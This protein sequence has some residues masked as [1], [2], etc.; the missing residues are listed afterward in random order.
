MFDPNRSIRLASG[1]LFNSESTWR[2]Y[3]PGAGDW[4]KTALLL[5]GPLIV[6]SALLAY[7]LGL[8]SEDA[9][10][11]GQFRPTIASTLLGMVSAAI[12][13]AVVAFIFGALAGVF[14][15]KSSFAFG[16]AATTLAFVPAYI[17]Q[18]LTQ[19][20]W[21]G[22]LLGI[23]LFVYALVLLWKIIPIY[24]EVPDGKRTGH[25]VSSLLATIIIMALF[26]MTIGR[27]LYPDVPDSPFAG[28][29][30]SSESVVSNSSN[31]APSGYL[32]DIIRQGELFKEAS[33]D[34]Y[35]PPADGRLSES[36]VRVYLEVMQKARDIRVEKG[37]AL[38]ALNEK[39]ERQDNVSMAEIM[40]ASKQSTELAMIEM[41][42]VNEDGGNWAEFQWVQRVL[43][44]LPAR[45]D[46]G[47]A[48]RPN[49]A[50]YEKYADRL[51][52]FIPR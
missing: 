52:E 46:D 36:Q 45:K 24:L 43:L 33:Q 26:S 30:G 3:L 14:G 6:F 44:Y 2:D 48:I 39:A 5:T 7:V 12:G 25:Y 9:A 8:F 51:A 47:D 17:G 40:A 42:V 4:S 19:L 50:L 27:F 20:P 28:M 21:I 41:Q 10:I 38:L 22:G 37:E 11:F 32:G 29:A 1:A 16:L 49:R 15:G 23:V 13:A 18:V 35:D 34:R 31:S